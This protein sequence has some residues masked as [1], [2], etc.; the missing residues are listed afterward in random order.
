MKGQTQAVSA[1]LI[2]GIIVGGI[3]T[4]YLWGVPQLEK[5]DVQREVTSTEEDVTT[6]YQEISET[7]SQGSDAS[8]T[9]DIDADSIQVNTKKDYIQIKNE[10]E[11][12][13]TR[14]FTWSLL[15]GDSFR[16]TSV[17]SQSGSYGIK[18]EH[19]PG[20][21]A[22]K[23]VGGES[24]SEIT[25]RI[26]FRNLCDRETGELS[27]IDIEAEGK[28]EAAGSSTVRITNQGEKIEN[29]VTLDRG[30]CQGITS[31]TSTK[32]QISLE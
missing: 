23:S 25:Y 13:A 32:I 1:V 26:D 5:R 28:K 19:Q 30:V 31:R 21:I 2:T 11:E 16:N 14:G 15:S 27:K 3:G 17:I 12:P 29:R 24:A 7:A 22:F 4:A 9:V 18:G 8:S 6:L 20:I 10:L